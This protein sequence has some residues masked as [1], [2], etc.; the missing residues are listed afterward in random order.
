MFFNSKSKNKILDIN[1][2]KLKVNLRDGGGLAYLDRESFEEKESLFYN[3]LSNTFDFAIDVGANYGFISLLLSKKM[4]CKKVISIEPNP[5]LI[6]YIKANI[7]LNFIRNIEVIEAVCGEKE[8]N[9][10]LF[11]INDKETQ[12]SRVIGD[13]KDWRIISQKMISLETI[14]QNN[15]FK[16][17]FCKIDTQGY[18]Y[19]IIKGAEQYLT[20]NSNWLIKCEFA[21]YWIEKQGGDPSLFLEYLIINYEVHEMP[22]RI[23]FQS[24]KISDFLLRPISIDDISSF[25]NYLISLNSSKLGWV[26]L[27]IMPK[28]KAYV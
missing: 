1:G 11:S 8:E 23:L 20:N 6:H 16:F 26:E 5:I 15:A 25:I 7:D 19:K 3:I 28:N 12:D 17:V 4:N 9:S 27:L 21:P 22:K 10:H 2:L 13:N 18:E 14:L 24:K